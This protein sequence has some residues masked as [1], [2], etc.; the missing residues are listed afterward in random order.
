[1]REQ[2]SK[3]GLRFESYLPP[4]LA[5]WV[6]DLVECGLFTDPSEAVFVFLRE[7][8]DLEPHA[9]LRQE[10]LSRSIEAALNDPRLS[11][12]GEEVREWL[13]KLAS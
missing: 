8:K 5:E 9:D 3:G 13:K 1:M 4:G 11:I 2:A 7:Q 6:L 12:P 10:I